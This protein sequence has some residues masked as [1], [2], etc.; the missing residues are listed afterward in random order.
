MPQKRYDNEKQKR[1]SKRSPP[2]HNSGRTH[3]NQHVE[4]IKFGSQNKNSDF[5]D[6]N[7]KSQ[8]DKLDMKSNHTKSQNKNSDSGG[9][10]IKSRNKQHGSL[11]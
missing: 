11:R 3:L 2:N 10:T 9:S 4:N 6:N 5:I 1:A 7:I 8:T